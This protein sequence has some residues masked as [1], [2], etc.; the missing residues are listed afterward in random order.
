MQKMITR[1]PFFNSFVNPCIRSQLNISTHITQRYTQIYTF[2]HVAKINTY[3]DSYTYSQSV[4]SQKNLI[5]VLLKQA[6]QN[7]HEQPPLYSLSSNE[8]LNP[9]IVQ[10]YTQQDPFYLHR[11]LEFVKIANEYQHGDQIPMANYTN[12]ENQ[13]WKTVFQVLDPLIRGHACKEYLE[14]YMSLRQDGY[15]TSDKIPEANVLNQYLQ[16]ETGFSLRPTIG[17]CDPRV[18]LAALAY[19]VCLFSQYIRHPSQPFFADEPDVIHQTLGHLPL[20]AN[21]DFAD[22]TAE[23][24]QASL[25]ATHD[26]IIRL[27]RCYWYTAEFGSCMEKSTRKLYGA[28]ILGSVN[29]IKNVISGN[30]TILSF[31]PLHA[32]ETEFSL[33][34]VQ[35][36]Y[37]CST[38]F[39]DMLLQMRHYIRNKHYK[40][41]RK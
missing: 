2:S 17:L 25:N 1:L 16:K 15:I 41:S 39:Q 29:E 32:A 36:F 33:D 35:S 27:N 11:R 5:D 18:F 14:P 9:T 8:H 26:E 7:T 38:S 20:L 19:R 23:I 28:G 10:Q 31:D 22:L 40:N 13:V 3:T 12:E 6:I 30:A 37:Y 34:Y 21:K 4:L 24:G